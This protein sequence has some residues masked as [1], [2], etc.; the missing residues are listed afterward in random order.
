MLRLECRTNSVWV[1]KEST[2]RAR[3]FTVFKTSELTRRLLILCRHEITKSISDCDLRDAWKTLVLVVPRRIVGR[4]FRSWDR[5]RRKHHLSN[6]VAPT[7]V[8]FRISGDICSLAGTLCMWTDKM[9]V[10]LNRTIWWR[11][12]RAQTASKEESTVGVS[13]DMGAPGD[14]DVA[15]ATRFRP[16]FLAA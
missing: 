4:D 8:V 2:F 3:V 16:A 7:A 1:R 6:T 5:D 9:L 13:A 10:T 12:W 15:K 14:T 11:S